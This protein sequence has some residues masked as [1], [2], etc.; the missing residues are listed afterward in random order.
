MNRCK[1]EARHYKYID[2]VRRGMAGLTR[3]LH[4]SPNQQYGALET[5]TV[6]SQ[7]QQLRNLK[8]NNVIDI[9]ELQ[10]F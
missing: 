2:D 7:P 5:F 4:N 1:P 3:S 9:V 10:A 6:E 8:N